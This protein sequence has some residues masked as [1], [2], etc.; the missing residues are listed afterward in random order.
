MNHSRKLASFCTDLRFETLPDDVIQ[1]AKLCILDYIANIYGSLELKAVSDVITYF[2]SQDTSGAST[3]LGCGFKT[4]LHYAAF[5]N[6]TTAEAI[7]AQDG[8]RFGGNHPGAAV[9]PAALGTAEER[10][11]GGKK[12]IEAVV[13]GYETA[14]RPAAA[15]HPWHTLNGFLPTG[16][17]GAFG[18]AAA[19]AK[20]Y[21]YDEIT[22]LNAIGNAG[23]ILPIS[24]AEHLMGGFTIKIV[25]GGQAASAGI[26][27]AGLAGT[28]LT[29]TP[30]VLEG[31]H[32]NGGFTKI[33][34]ASD[35][36]LEKLSDRLGDT[37]SIMDI[38]FKPYTACRH[39]HG[40][41]QAALELAGEKN[42]S[43][44]NISEINVHTYGIAELAVGKGVKEKDSFVSAQFSIPY[45]VAACLTDGE[46]SPLQLTEKRISDKSLIRLSEKITV[47]TDETLNQLYPDK[48]ASRV[49]IR[50]KDNQIIKR[51]IDIPKGDPRDPMTETDIIQKVKQYAGKR[52]AD[53]IETVISKVLN[54]EN[55]SDIT[56]LTRLI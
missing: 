1:K 12:V 15:M 10:R 43:I 20:I 13:A 9:I 31:S 3:A 27:A 39:T 5:I 49:E 26:L 30:Q 19:A 28:G 4:N 44:E 2:Q 6:G 35:P 21:D 29:G 38:Y 14:N 47:S 33:T 40:A 55:V 17:C 41:A 8:Y 34:S 56:E 42:F 50:L 51:Q 52:D 37:Y 24:M 7:E 18:A 32:L 22:M 25:Q 36:K 46:L 11:I 16:T 53:R 48:T 45:V 23:Y 54:L